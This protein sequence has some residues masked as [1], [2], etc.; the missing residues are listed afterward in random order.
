MRVEGRVW[1]RERDR[2]RMRL[3]GSIVADGG[4]GVRAMVHRL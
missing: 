1:T 2:R 4:A 3:W